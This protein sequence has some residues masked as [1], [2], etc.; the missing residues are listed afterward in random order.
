ML[1]TAVNGLFA[2]IAGWRIMA[3]HFAQLP[4]DQAR[5]GAV[6][7][8][9]A[10]PKVLSSKPEREEPARWIADP[11]VWIAHVTRACRR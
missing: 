9:Q 3:V 10:V 5:Q 8:L 6:T 2:A 11:S 7:V 4:N 1:Q